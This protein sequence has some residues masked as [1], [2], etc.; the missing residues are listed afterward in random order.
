MDCYIGIFQDIVFAAMFM[1]LSHISTLAVHQEWAQ[2]IYLNF[3]KLL[4]CLDYLFYHQIVFCICS[5][6][7]KFY[8]FLGAPTGED[9]GVE[10]E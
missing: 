10:Q 4:R 2:M 5:I 7:P 1:D 8:C 9:E 3:I 6:L